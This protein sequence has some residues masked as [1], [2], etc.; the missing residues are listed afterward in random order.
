MASDSSFFRP[1]T[2]RV[3]V[4]HIRVSQVA[5]IGS[6]HAAQPRDLV[7]LTLAVDEE[8]LFARGRVS[9]DN[10]VLVHD[11][12]PPLDAGPDGGGV[13][14][15]DARVRGPQAVKTLSEERAQ[16]LVCLDG[17]DKERVAP[18][19]WLVEDV[20]KGGARGLLLVRDV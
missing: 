19:V 16:T 7:A 14:L 15:L 11:G 3:T 6:G 1:T 9:P 20:E 4:Q 5:F 2:S 18:G 8:G 10:R 17:V 13:D 12:L